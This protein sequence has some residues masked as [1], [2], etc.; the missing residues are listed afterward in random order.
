M[1]RPAARDVERLQPA[2]DAEQRQ[3]ALGG[4]GE[5][6]QLVLVGDAVDVRA[7]RRMAGPGRRRPGRG[8]G[9]RSRAGRRGGRAAR[10]CRRRSRGPAARPRSRPP[11]AAPGCRSA[12]S[13]AAAGRGRARCGRAPSPSPARLRQQ[14]V[15]DDADQRRGG[16]ARDGDGAEAGAGHRADKHAERRAAAIVVPRE[17][18]CGLP[19]PQGVLATRRARPSPARTGTAGSR[20][21]PRARCR[22]AAGGRSARVAASTAAIASSWISPWSAARCRRTSSASPAA[23]SPRSLGRERVLDDDQ[24]MA[25]VDASSAPCVGPRPAER[26]ISCTIAREISA[27]ADPSGRTRRAH[28]PSPR[29][30]R[31]RRHPHQDPDRRGWARWSYPASSDSRTTESAERSGSGRG[32]LELDF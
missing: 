11:P 9:R 17:R 32:V 29:R 8:R 27:A 14:L 2:A 31:R 23:T 10:P 20:R 28:D 30:A 26:A 13:R 15:R 16:R 19:E 25:A 6:R 7:E 21:P 18:A 1:Q 5:Q 4:A 3:V 12:A 22:S 24:R